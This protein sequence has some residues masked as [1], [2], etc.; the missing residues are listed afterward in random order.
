MPITPVTKSFQQASLKT[1]GE[2][3]E[4]LVAEDFLL[5]DPLFLR[6]DHGL[7]MMFL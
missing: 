7:V 1:K 5:S 2:G 6:S 3:G 4:W